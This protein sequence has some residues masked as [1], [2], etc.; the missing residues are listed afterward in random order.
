MIILIQDHAD[1]LTPECCAQSERTQDINFFDLCA[2]YDLQVKLNLA[3]AVFLKP[4]YSWQEKTKPE[5]MPK[6]VAGYLAQFSTEPNRVSEFL[7]TNPVLRIL[8]KK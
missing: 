5:D 1:I 8:W 7:M 4:A 3:T 2:N 6:K